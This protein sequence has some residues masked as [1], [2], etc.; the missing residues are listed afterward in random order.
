MSIFQYNLRFNKISSGYDNIILFDVLKDIVP[1]YSIKS[2]IDKQLSYIYNNYPELIIKLKDKIKVNINFNYIY[3]VKNAEVDIKKVFIVDMEATDNIINLMIKNLYTYN[4]SNIPNLLRKLMIDEFPNDDDIMS[5]NFLPLL[6][7]KYNDMA[8]IANPIDILIN[9]SLEELEPLS[10]NKLNIDDYINIYNIINNIF[11]INDNTKKINPKIINLR[12]KLY[13][14]DDTRYKIN[15]N[16]YCTDYIEVDANNR[17]IVDFLDYISGPDKLDDI[18]KS[19]CANIYDNITNCNIYELPNIPICFSAFHNI[20]YNTTN[21]EIIRDIAS[22]P[23]YN[24]LLLNALP[25]SKNIY[26]TPNK[27][28]ETDYTFYHLL[29]HIRNRSI[30]SR[31]NRYTNDK[32]NNEIN[33]TTLI[34]NEYINIFKKYLIDDPLHNSSQYIRLTSENSSESNFNCIDFKLYTIWKSH[35]NETMLNTLDSKAFERELNTYNLSNI[36]TIYTSLITI[37][38]NEI[39]YNTKYRNKNIGNAFSTQFSFHH[40]SFFINKMIGDMLSTKNIIN[41]D[42]ALL[43]MFEALRGMPRNIELNIHNTNK[44]NINDTY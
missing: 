18:N 37:L 5:S 12:I 35:A 1:P 2:Q 29:K 36:N 7:S 13:N 3:S 6:N 33:I 8:N 9:I 10:L 38:F 23:E 4:S 44:E 21:N 43:Y 22:N 41:D 39:I 27:T 34:K 15:Y 11:I 19:V 31:L 32:E 42:I 20:I 25:S 14:F 30:N 24:F 17:L 26:Y 28:L 16:D 40:T